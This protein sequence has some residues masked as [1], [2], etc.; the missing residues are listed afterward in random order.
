[1]SSVRIGNP[2]HCLLPRLSDI[3]YARDQTVHLIFQT[4]TTHSKGFFN[5]MIVNCK[6]AKMHMRYDK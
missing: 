3:S 1:M 6:G 4:T 5:H 2:D